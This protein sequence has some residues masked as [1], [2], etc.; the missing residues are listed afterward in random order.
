[1]AKKDRDVLRL[2][3]HLGL[4]WADAPTKRPGARPGPFGGRAWL[5]FSRGKLRRFGPTEPAVLA[6]GPDVAKDP[7]INCRR[8]RQAVWRFPQLLLDHFRVDF[9]GRHRLAGCLEHGVG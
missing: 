6:L 1:M 4:G 7:G 3:R 8:G 9:R 2:T 5:N